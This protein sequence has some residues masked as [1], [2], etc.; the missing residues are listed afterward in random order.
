MHL[1]AL[2]CSPMHPIDWT[3]LTSSNVIPV[4][5]KPSPG[6]PSTERQPALRPTKRRMKCLAIR[7]GRR[8]EE[9]V[10][11]VEAAAAHRRIRLKHRSTTPRVGQWASTATT[12]PPANAPT[13]CP[14]R[15]RTCQPLLGFACRVPEV[16][17]SASSDQHGSSGYV[18]SSSGPFAVIRTCSSSLTASS[19]TGGAARASTHNTIPSCT[20]PS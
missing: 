10:A 7:R 4:I 2:C 9:A 14:F 3:T 19:P 20:S 17:P 12:P 8:V 1:A 6:A 15:N 18:L 11:A 13:S 5:V 16:A